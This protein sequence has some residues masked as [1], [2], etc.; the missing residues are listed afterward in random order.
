MKQVT[1]TTREVSN[2]RR[3]IERRTPRHTSMAVGES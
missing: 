3:S 2:Y 1:I